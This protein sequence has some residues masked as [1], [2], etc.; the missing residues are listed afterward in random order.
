VN[1]YEGH[2]TCGPVGEAL[3]LPTAEVKTLLPA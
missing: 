3:R 2:L 1:T